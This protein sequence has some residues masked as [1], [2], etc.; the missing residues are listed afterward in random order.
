MELL[1]KSGTIVNA[2]ET[3][4]S[5]LLIADGKVK[6]LSMN[7]DPNDKEVIDAQGMLVLPGGV[8]VHVHLSLPMAGTISADDFYTGGKAAAFGGTTTIIDFVS[9]EKESL[10]ENIDQWH[11]KVSDTASV[12]IGCH[13]NVTRFNDSILAELPTLLDEG[14]SSIK[15]FTAYNNR[16]RLS[17]GEIFKIM[18]VA[19]NYGLLTMVHAEN[20]DVIEELVTEAR[21]Q[22]HSSP[23]WHA[24]TRPAW[25]AVEATLR[26]IA[27]SAQ[28]E[29]PCYIVHMNSAGEVDQLEYGLSKGVHVMGET[30]P[31]YLLLTEDELTREDG[32]KFVCSPPLRQKTDN[33][34]LF[35]GLQTKSIKVVATDHCPFFYNGNREIVYEGKKISIAGKELGIDD[36]SK[37]PNGLPGLGDRM[38]I[39]WT[40][41]VEKKRLSPNDFVAL[42]CTN[43]AKIFGLYPQKG[44]I[45]VGSDA[46]IVIWDPTEEIEYGVRTAKHR[47][48]YN[49]YEGYHLKGI[50]TTVFLRGKKIVHKEKWFGKAGMGQFIKRKTGEILV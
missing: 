42:M 3:F 6:Q 35:E 26:S 23:I 44:T 11:K 37:I 47:T 15:V 16:L 2:Q 32:R 1:I 4:Q 30:C 9:H 31:Q 5:D 50:P 40:M 49:L 13:M 34:R 33:Q 29:A 17:D 18:R 45:E 21:F 36:F 48:D 38:P 43:P 27:L 19:G 10:H 39:M 14:I 7:I 12:D 28:A 22:G 41:G 8:D 20:G 25:G 46:D 24:K